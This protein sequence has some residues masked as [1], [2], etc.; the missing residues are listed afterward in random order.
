VKTQKNLAQY[1]AAAASRPAL[2]TLALSDRYCRLVVDGCG[3]HALLDLA[4]H[5]QEGLLDVGSAL[6]GGLQERDSEAVSEL[7]KDEV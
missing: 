2:Y 6:G 1:L 4:G 7:L 3:A 5:G